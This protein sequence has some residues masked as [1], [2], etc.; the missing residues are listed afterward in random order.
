M[1]GRL[2]ELREG[3]FMLRTVSHNRLIKRL[4]QFE[5]VESIRPVDNLETRGEAFDKNLA[6]A[7]KIL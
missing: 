6:R 1:R 4:V 5:E 3:G 2:G 7:R